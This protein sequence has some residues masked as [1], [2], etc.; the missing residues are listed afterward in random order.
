MARAAPSPAD[1][2][3]QSGKSSWRLDRPAG[4]AA[5]WLCLLYNSEGF[6]IGNGNATPA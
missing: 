5:D 2:A 6:E 4:R 3:W 1:I